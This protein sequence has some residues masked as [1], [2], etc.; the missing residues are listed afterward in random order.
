MKRDWQG[1]FSFMNQ[2]TNIEFEFSPVQIQWSWGRHP[3][4]ERF[5]EYSKK[6]IEPC[7][8]YMELTDTCKI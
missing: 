7:E 5:Q 4:L 1:I 2:N 6:I 3:Y 8:K